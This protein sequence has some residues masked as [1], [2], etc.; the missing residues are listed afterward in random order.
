MPST[1]T[2]TISRTLLAALLLAAGIG[3]AAGQAC[4]SGPDGFDRWLA[5][6][7][8][9]AQAQGI[10]AGGMQRGLA[11]IEYD[12]RVIGLDRG[13]R[14]FKLSFEDFYARRVSQSMIKRGQS[15]IAQRKGLFD[16][17]QSRYGV[18][19]QILVAIWGLETNFGGDGGGKFSI[20]QSLATLAYD[21]RRS[22]FFE[23]ELTNALRI[24]DRGDIS[25]ERMRGGWAGEIGP[26]Q[27]LP[28][29]YVQ[30]AV[31]FDGDGRRDLFGSV[32]DMLAS[33][34][35]YLKQKGWRAGQPW[36]EGAAN[37]GVIREWNKAEV[38]VK[39]IAVMAERMAGR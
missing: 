12:R 4:G 29:S 39:T 1:P 3:P 9:R 27:F 34:A 23:N 19:P 20:V 2:T 36:G 14:S 38:Y 28:S 11:G 16:Q 25:V 24:I 18:P 13:Q 22:A 17:I 6:Y 30:F 31:D 26:M 5:A 33:T 21:C 15:I 37:Y 32:P 7:K 10:S 8:G 35:N